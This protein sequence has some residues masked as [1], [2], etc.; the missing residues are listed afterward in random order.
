MLIGI[1]S[2]H[3]WILQQL[4]KGFTS[5]EVRNAFQ[6]LKDYGFFYHCSFICG[7]IGETRAEMLAITHFAKEIGADSINVHR[8]QAWPFTPLKELVEKTSG[9]YM[10][11]DNYVYS[12]SYGMDELKHI[13][14][15]IHRSFYTPYQVYKSLRKLY[16]IRVLR[17]PG[18]FAI[19]QIFLRL[20]VLLYRILSKRLKRRLGIR[21]KIGIPYT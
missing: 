6:T 2:P 9:Y 11:S 3:D 13:R 10:T 8:L 19:F 7:N 20:P 16:R 17:F 4:N 21:R 1:E 12:D 5:Q 15:V 18:F 14:T